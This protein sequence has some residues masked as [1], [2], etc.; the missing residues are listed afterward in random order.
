MDSEGPDQPVQVE[1]GFYIIT[2]WH[3]C[4]LHVFNPCPAG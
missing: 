4:C 1:Q 3:E 2:E